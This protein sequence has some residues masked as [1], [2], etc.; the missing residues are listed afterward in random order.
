MQ[1][2]VLPFEIWLHQY[3][4][5]ALWGALLLRELIPLALYRQSWLLHGQLLAALLLSASAVCAALFVPRAYGL[6]LNGLLGLLCWACALSFFPRYFW[7]TAPRPLWQLA[8]AGLY[9][10]AILVLRAIYLRRWQMRLRGHGWAWMLDWAVE[11]SLY[12]RLLAWRSLRLLGW[13][14]EG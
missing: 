5:A 1:R 3:A 9:L 2:P 8:L 6:A 12:A 13:Q 7:P 4:L 10:L 11:R 14:P